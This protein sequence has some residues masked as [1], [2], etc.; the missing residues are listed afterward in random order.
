MSS[1]EQIPAGEAV[2][3]DYASRTGQNAI[4]VQRD[5]A[6]VEETYVSGEADS[7]A[8]LGMLFVRPDIGKN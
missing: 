5:D 1:N 4:P 2:D 8:Q 6:P 3:N 7:D